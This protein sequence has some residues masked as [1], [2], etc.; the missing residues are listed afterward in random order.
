MGDFNA[1]QKEGKIE[2]LALTPLPPE[3]Y[4]GNYNGTEPLFL[5]TPEWR[6]CSLNNRTVKQQHDCVLCSET[7]SLLASWLPG[8]SEGPCSTHSG[9]GFRSGLCLR[10][11]YSA[12]NL[13]SCGP[14]FPSPGQ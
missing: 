1:L 10:L 14:W 2:E 12:K 9:C 6:S 3:S 4:R 7:C 13:S 8:F 11:C 5:R